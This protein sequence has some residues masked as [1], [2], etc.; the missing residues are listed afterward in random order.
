MFIQYNKIIQTYT[1]NEQMSLIDKLLTFKNPDTVTQDN[2]NQAQMLFTQGIDINQT[3]FQQARI[4]DPIN[5]S[6][7][8]KFI[9]LPTFSVTTPVFRCLK[10]Y[11][12]REMLIYGNFGISKSVSIMLYSH[13]SY[14]VNTFLL[15]S[16]KRAEFQKK[17]GED[18]KYIPQKVFY[19]SM[20]P[21]PS[22]DYK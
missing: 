10:K 3:I 5:F 8:S 14:L 2:L 16:G 20:I 18:A 6:M 13:F 15:L 4:I 7:N 21:I 17:L 11:N 19:W 12:N 9:F 22:R 1:P